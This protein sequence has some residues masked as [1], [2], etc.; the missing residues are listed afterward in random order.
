MRLVTHERRMYICVNAAATIDGGHQKP[1]TPLPKLP[2]VAL[3][4]GLIWKLF[5][6]I[7]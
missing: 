5:E 3:A 2:R 4:E 7:P 1:A 6:L